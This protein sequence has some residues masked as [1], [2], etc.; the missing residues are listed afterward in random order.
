[1]QTGNWHKDEI[2]NWSGVAREHGITARNGGQ[3]VKEFATEMGF[4]TNS[5]DIKNGRTRMRAKK[6]KMP[7]GEI[8]VPC[9]KTASMIK[10]DWADM[11]RSGELTLGEPCAPYTL[12]RYRVV[13]GRVEKSE[14]VVYGR[15]VPLVYIRKKLLQK[16][17]GYMRLHTNLELQNMSKSELTH[18]LNI[19]SVVFDANAEDQELRDLS[20]KLE[21]TRMLA[22]W[23]DHSTLLGKG[24]VMITV[25]NLYDKAVFKTTS[26]LEGLHI[27]NVQAIVEQPQLHMLAVCSSTVED[28]AAL[29][30]DRN[31]CIREL[32]TPLYDSRGTEIRDELVFFYKHSRLKEA[33]STGGVY[34]CGSCGCQS[35]MMDDMAYSM[36]CKYRTLADLQSVALDGK[37]GKQVGTIRPFQRLNAKELQEKLSARN[38]YHTCTTK[39]DLQKELARVLKG[40]QRVPTLLLDNPAMSLADMQL[41]RYSVLDCEP[42]HDLKGH[43]ANL[44][45]E[46]PH[47][48]SDI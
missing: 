31:S 12:T 38:V 44:F 26:K 15:K 10:S 47:I 30:G 24:Y 19:A 43:L 45:T 4:D 17:E 23:H 28:Q 36:R 39:R 9:H 1:M 5:F 42:L 34:K 13:D 40:V 3:I 25:K 27:D 46:I 41:Q 14:C 21:R 29:I 6:L 8:S 32:S 22:I 18:I 16:H 7:G 2:I 11:I 37:Y 20:C 35:N 48:I 33:L